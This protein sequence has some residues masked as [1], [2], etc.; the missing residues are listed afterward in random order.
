MNFA[1]YLEFFPEIEL[2]VVLSPD[3]HHDFSQAN[4]AL[5]GALLEE[6]VLPFEPQEADELTEY[7]PCFRIPKTEQFHALVLWRAGLLDYQ[8]ILMTYTQQ[9]ELID[10]RVIAG[11]YYDG[12]LLTQSVATFDED[13]SI[14]I[15]S[16]QNKADVDI[17][18]AATS[19]SYEL[20]LL[21]DGTIGNT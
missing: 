3:A 9:A 17:Y 6:F 2:P 15:V 1:R 4:E 5:P 11:T 18:D 14:Y 7:V 19:R 16:G 13:G 21:P 12:K 8:Y 20:E 10:R